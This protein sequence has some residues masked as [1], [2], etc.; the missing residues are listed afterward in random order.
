[1]L[2]IYSLDLLEKYY[3]LI[4]WL[5]HMFKFKNVLVLHQGRHLR[6][7]NLE[8]TQSTKSTF[9]QIIITCKYLIIKLT[10]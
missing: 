5:M 6:Y 1:M 10:F 9:G 8:G 3:N 4:E 2:K 7:L